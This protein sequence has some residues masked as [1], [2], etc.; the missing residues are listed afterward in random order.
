MRS[1]FTFFSPFVTLLFLFSQH[2]ESFGQQGSSATKVSC[3]LGLELCLSRPEGDAP[4]YVRQLASDYS[5]NFGT[6]ASYKRLWRPGYGVY[7][8]AT[9]WPVKWLGVDLGG[10]L[11]TYAVSD[12]SEIVYDPPIGLG[13]SNSWGQI[14]TTYLNVSPSI[15]LRAKWRNLSLIVGAEANVF[16]FG[17]TSVH[18]KYQSLLGNTETNENTRIDTQDQPI[19]LDPLHGG[20]IADYSNV[21]NRNH[22]AN[23]IWFSG[24]ARLE[25]R[26]FVLKGSPVL[27]FA[28]RVPFSEILRSNS[29]RWSFVSV[30]DT[31][32]EE[33]NYGTKISTMSLHIGWAF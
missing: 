12:R 32:L 33:M 26:L 30:V 20:G 23:P 8:F 15:G 19:Y 24:F 2:Q 22:G 10:R 3:Q 17:K 18:E 13:L 25:Y 27:G 5:T 28:W 16:A 6:Q 29:P 21:T 1:S 31:D 4:S 9:L 14:K 7:G 11:G